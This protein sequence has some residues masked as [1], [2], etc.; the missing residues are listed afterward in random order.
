M[1]NVAVV[2]G[3][4]VL[5]EE[6]CRV[7]CQSGM[8]ARGVGC[9]AGLDDYLRVQ[10]CNVVVLEIDLPREDGFS[11]TLRLREQHERLGVV[12]VTARAA[13]EDRVRG[14]NAG[15]DAYLVKPVDPLEFV[16]T[17][18]SVCR[19]TMPSVGT[20][21]ASQAPWVLRRLG[22]ELAGPNGRSVALTAAEH[23]LLSQ[24]AAAPGRPVSRRALL[25]MSEPGPACDL[26]KLDAVVRRLRRK[27][28]DV[29]G[30]DLPV[31][32]AH[33]VGYIATEPLHRR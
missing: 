24:L 26:R 28:E 12:M 5:R 13:L 4:C 7:L 11:I 30:L 1:L 29:I 18:K 20:L 32:A 8:D 3:D 33:G 14:L 27:V 17:L 22:W 31:R 19:R 10:P 15:A 21:A 16:A 23:T 9:G 2:E 6:L 25:A